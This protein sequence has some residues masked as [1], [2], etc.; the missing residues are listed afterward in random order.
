M[1]RS[2][3]LSGKKLSLERRGETHGL[4]GKKE[5]KI[6]KEKGFGS[7]YSSRK[8]TL[9][10]LKRINPKPPKSRAQTSPKFWK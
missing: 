9:R 7:I 5:K 1:S 6:M 8:A 3:D 10:L 2:R 4:R